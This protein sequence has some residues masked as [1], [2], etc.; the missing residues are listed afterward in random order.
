M[1]IILAAERI[2]GRKLRGG[3]SQGD[4]EAEGAEAA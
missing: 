4:R 3:V 2:W 1:G